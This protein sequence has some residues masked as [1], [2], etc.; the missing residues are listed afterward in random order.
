MIDTVFTLPLP[1][2]LLAAGITL[3]AGLVKGMVG[4]AMPMLIISGL[5]SFLSAEMAL[6]MLIVPTLV[7]NGVQ[8]LRQG[9]AAAW[10]SIRKFR[11]FLMVGLVCLLLS[12][13]SYAFLSPRFLFLL[14]G[15]PIFVFAALQLAGWVLVIAPQHRRR[16]EWI[17]G[18]FAGFVG[19]VSGVWGP[20]TVS[21]LTA[22]NTEKSEQMRVQGVIY[23]L[24]AVALLLAHVQS[25]VV[26]AVT[27]P[28]SVL[29]VVPAMVGMIIGLR[30]QGRMD[31]ARFRRVTLIVLVVVSANLI[32]R[33][34]VG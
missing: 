16:A 3:V 18:G 28:L 1:V 30:F 5:S 10:A 15:L 26:N 20:P 2:F 22:L 21:F 25:G 4:F 8:A 7:S 9:A 29:M 31:A 17:I 34:F 6:G 13:Q 32:R 33:A 11:L 27:L 23:G 19:G 24:G 12:A 14:I